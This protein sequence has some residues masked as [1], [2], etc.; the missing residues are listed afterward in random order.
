M[1]LC[2][3]D[4]NRI[5]LVRGRGVHDVTGILD[6]LPPL[7]YPV[8][9][10]DHLIANLENLRARMEQLADKAAPQ[11]IDKARFLSPVANPS[12]IIGTPANYLRMSRRRG[13]TPRSRSTA[14]ASSAP[15]RSR[16]CFSRHR[17]R[18]SGRPRAS[19][20]SFRTGAPITRPS[21][22]S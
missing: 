21:S 6:A 17:A 7:R 19:R 9:F 16:D 13:A 8:A 3:Y 15:S 1:K 5:G 4:D 22:A 18:W 20:S 2:R 12:K 14:P 11:P 10:G